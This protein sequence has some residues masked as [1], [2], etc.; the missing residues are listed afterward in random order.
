MSSR[1]DLPPILATTAG[2]AGR[3]AETRWQLELGR[4]IV[5]PV[6]RGRDVPRGDGR[7]MV[8]VPGFGA[9]DQTLSYSRHGSGGWAIARRPVGSSPTSVLGPRRRASR[10]TYRAGV[11]APRAAGGIIGHSRGGHYARALGS[12]RPDLVSHA[13][14]MGAGLR[15][16]LAVSYPTG[17]AVA[18][19]VAAPRT[20]RPGRLP[21]LSHRRLRLRVHPQ[22]HSAVS[23]TDLVR[24]TSIYS[25]GD[26]VVRWPSA[27]APDADCV[28]VS[29][30][31]VGLIFNRKTYRALATV[32][33]TPRAGPDRLWHSPQTTPIQNRTTCT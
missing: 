19:A 23:R 6:L 3:L 11:R 28:E 10:A 22:L 27:L 2:G 29:G 1:T 16:M 31:H 4:L 14:S 24:L 13:V 12:R 32:L 25:K 5:D 21:P 15:E 20:G 17:L 7:P 30:S 18:A 8:L 33:A 9:G 26:G